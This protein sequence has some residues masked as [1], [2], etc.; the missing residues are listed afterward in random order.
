MQTFATGVPSNQALAAVAE[1]RSLRPRKTT[2]LI[3]KTGALTMYGKKSRT[4][5]LIHRRGNVSIARAPY[6]G[7]LISG[8]DALTISGD[9]VV[10]T[11]GLNYATSVGRRSKLIGR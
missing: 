8:E 10:F 11:A 4:S 5:L 6:A 1:I 2:T 9:A 7:V 3:R